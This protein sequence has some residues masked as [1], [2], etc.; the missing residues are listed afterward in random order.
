M[1]RLGL[2]LDCSDQAVGAGPAKPPPY[3]NLPPVVGD[4]AV[5]ICNA[6]CFGDRKRYGDAGER[7]AR[8]IP[9]SDNDRFQ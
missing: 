6:V 3:G 8:C 5:D 4:V 7:L 9:N 1:Q 2:V